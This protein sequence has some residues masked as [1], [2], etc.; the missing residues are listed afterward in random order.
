MIVMQQSSIL[1]EENSSDLFRS[2]VDLKADF[3]KQ[4]FGKK[5]SEPIL[6]ATGRKLLAG[7]MKISEV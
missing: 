4:M 6:V 7:G 3:A 5:G 2:Y 1:K